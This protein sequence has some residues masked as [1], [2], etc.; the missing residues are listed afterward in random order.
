MNSENQKVKKK[1]LDTP[2]SVSRVLSPSEFSHARILETVFRHMANI[3]SDA[4]IE[5]G[6]KL[7]GEDC[8]FRLT[9]KVHK[10]NV[11][12]KEVK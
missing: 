11:Y 10:Y 2:L 5:R 7:P 4:I 9:C 1:L 3:I 12:K 8:I 6:N